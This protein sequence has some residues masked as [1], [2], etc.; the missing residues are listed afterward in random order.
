MSLSR[1]MLSQKANTSKELNK[2]INDLFNQLSLPLKNKVQ[3]NHYGKIYLFG[4][5]S[6]CSVE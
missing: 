2:R 4:K 5:Y 1:E 6:V 3:M